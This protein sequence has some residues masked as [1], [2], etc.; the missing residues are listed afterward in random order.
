[1]TINTTYLP[2]ELRMREQWVVWD[3]AYAPYLNVLLGAMG[4]MTSH[5]SARP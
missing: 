3:N 4:G 2:A 1:M 5:V